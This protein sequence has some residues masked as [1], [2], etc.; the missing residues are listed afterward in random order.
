MDVRVRSIMVVAAAATAAVAAGFA[1]A[2]VDATAAPAKGNA[3]PLVAMLLPENVTARWEGQDRPRFIAA[4]KQLVPG[5]QVQVQNALN[6]P[7][8]QQAQAEAALV[9]GAKVLVVAAVDQKAAAVI[10]N[11][12]KRQNVP[13]IAYDRLIRNSP[14]AAYVSFDSVAVGRAE[15]GWIAKHTTRGDRIVIINGSPTDDNAHLVNKG[16][17]QVMDPL[18]KTEA[19]VKV[20]EQWVPGWDPSKAQQIMEQIL[21]RYSNRVDAVVSA[22]DGMAGGIIAAL[23]SQ[24]LDGKVPVSGQ[25]ATIEGLQRVILGTQGVSVFKDIR[26]QAQGAA[27]VAA[28]FIAGKT[29]KAFNGKVANGRVQVPSVLL[30]VQGIDKA[31]VGLLI[32][33]GYVT[34]AQLCKGIP[35]IGVCK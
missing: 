16:I 28:D 29:P 1:G 2:T 13:V 15:A 5:V 25:D 34:K 21:T 30:K 19:R 32:R 18:F 7:A 20:A 31:N 11:N 33:N 23:K 8:K 35:K 9:K 22:N 3:G 6:D 4:L 24:E 14:L 10:V 17:H 27:R 12:A 26:L